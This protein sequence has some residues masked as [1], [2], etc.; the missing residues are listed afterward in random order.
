MGDT[1]YALGKGDGKEAWRYK[2]GAMF[3]APPIIANGVLYTA[4]EEGYLYA[5][6]ER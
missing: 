5:F 1:L 4:T 6:D 2:A 3:T